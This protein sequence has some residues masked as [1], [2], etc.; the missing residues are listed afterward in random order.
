M[1]LVLSLNLTASFFSIPSNSQDFCSQYPG[2]CDGRNGANHF[3]SVKLCHC[4]QCPHTET[5]WTKLRG[6]VSAEICRQKSSSLILLAPARSREFSAVYYSC[7]PAHSV[8]LMY[9]N[10]LQFKKKKKK[11]DTCLSLPGCDVKLT[12][13]SSGGRS[14]PAKAMGKEGGNCATSPAQAT[15]L[16]GEVGAKTELAKGVF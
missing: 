2:T 8:S 16:P 11:A 3:T 12:P 15:Q 9:L 14:K 13:A 5:H 4:T 10:N 1:E 7:S 6:P